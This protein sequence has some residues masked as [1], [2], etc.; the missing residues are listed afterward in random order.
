[1]RQAVAA[2]RPAK[3]P[4]PWD[5]VRADVDEALFDLRDIAR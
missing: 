2:A 4:K 5:E 1:M 3:Q